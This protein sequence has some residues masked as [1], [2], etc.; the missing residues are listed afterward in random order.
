[1]SNE[2]APF[3]I[4]Q[5]VIAIKDHSSGDFHRGDEFKVL[6]IKPCVC[7]HWQVDIGLQTTSKY[8]LCIPGGKCTPVVNSVAW[9]HARCFAPI[10]PA[11]ESITAELAQK[12]ME[13]G[14]TPDVPL[15]VKDA[16]NAN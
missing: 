6:H 8:V 13:V 16:V 7:D 2:Q 3:K 15:K 5:R 9:Y 4:G 10:Q 11:Y 14:D 12:G 1:M